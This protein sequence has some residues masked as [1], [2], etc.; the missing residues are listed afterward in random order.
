MSVCIEEKRNCRIVSKLSLVSCLCAVFCCA[1]I[2]RSFFFSFP[3]GKIDLIIYQYGKEF[4]YIFVSVDCNIMQNNFDSRLNRPNEDV[5]KLLF[6]NIEKNVL[7][8]A[9]AVATIKA[10][11]S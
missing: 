8:V 1:F 5:E 10:K 2:S 11:L 7:K 3:F 9:A 4:G 6:F